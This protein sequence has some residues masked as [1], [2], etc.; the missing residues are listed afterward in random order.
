MGLSFERKRDKRNFE[1]IYSML[2]FY[3]WHNILITHCNTYILINPVI[4]SLFL[5]YRKIIFSYPMSRNILFFRVVGVK[6]KCLVF[7]SPQIFLKHD[8]FLSDGKHFTASR[9]SPRHHIREGG[10]MRRGGHFR[11]WRFAL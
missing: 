7:P 6:V 8:C 1:V 4:V 11:W 9:L 2:Y 10:E 5:C 3:C